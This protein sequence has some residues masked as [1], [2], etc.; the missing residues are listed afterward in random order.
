[1]WPR[2]PAHVAEATSGA[3][4]PRQAGP[5]G[6]RGD[7]LEER[8]RVLKPLVVVGAL[9]LLAAACGDDDDSSAVRPP[10]QPAKRPPRPRP[11]TT[12]AGG[13]T[14]TAAGGGATTTAA[15]GG[16]RAASARPASPTTPSTPSRARTPASSPPTSSARP[17]KPLK[18][19]GEPI[20]IGFQNPQGDPNGSFPEMHALAEAAVEVHQRGARRPGQQPVRGQ[21]RPA[22]P[23]RDLHRWRSTRPTRRSAPTSWPARTRSSWSRRSTSSATTSRSTQQA[24]VENVHRRV[25]DH[26]RRLHRAGRVLDRRRRRLPRRPHGAGLRRHPGA[27]GHAGRGAVGRHAARR[28]LL[29]RPREEA[30]RRAAGRGARR[31]RAGRLDARPRAHRR[32]DQAG[33][34]RRDPAGHPGPRLRP[35][36]HHLL[37][38]GR[39]L[40]EP[41]RRPRPRSAG[42]PTASRSS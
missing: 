15:G 32:A 6:T 13:A 16:A 38:P 20:V 5:P 2:V 7:D 26:H 9:A 10:R 29:L 22:D 34:P 21:G 28:G 17:D 3:G 35:R 27:Q 42:R 39:R 25:A 41:R 23:A 18:A 8:S 40:L 30:A 12:A 4:G 33:D 11:T 19:E 24:G 36:R 1:M 37:G 14:T 31:L